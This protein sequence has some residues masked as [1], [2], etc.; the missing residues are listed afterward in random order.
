MFSPGKAIDLQSGALKLTR[1]NI[2]GDLDS[3]TPVIN[4]A[5]GGTQ[6]MAAGNAWNSAVTGGGGSV[7]T[8]DN[9][10]SR[11]DSS[12]NIDTHIG[13]FYTVPAASCAKLFQDGVAGPCTW[14]PVLQFGGG[15]SGIT[16][17]TQTGIYTQSLAS[18]GPLVT[19]LHIQ[20]SSKGTSTGAATITGLPGNTVNYYGTCSS[21]FNANMSALTAPLQG[22]TQLGT[23]AIQFDQQGA[24]GT[25][26]VADT[27]FT[28]TSNIYVN[29]L[30]FNG[31]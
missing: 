16:Y 10:F 24:T 23:A 17:T 18:Y 25:A 4:I 8:T 9:A 6:L 12:S 27:N 7:I 19:E 20:L 30:F 29:C 22:F 11:V 1:S 31:Q 15:T 14:T 28:N 2:A 3:G 21:P 5:N 26:N 13:D